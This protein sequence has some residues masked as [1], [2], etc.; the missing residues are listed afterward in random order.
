MCYHPVVR[1]D[2]AVE[3][4]RAVDGE[5]GVVHDEIAVVLGEVIALDGC[6]SA[7]DDA[8]GEGVEL[9]QK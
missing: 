7:E 8:P 4:M 9:L 6:E 2:K 5:G 3:R 1:H